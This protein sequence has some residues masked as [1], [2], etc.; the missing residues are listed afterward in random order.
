MTSDGYLLENA[1]PHAG[2]RLDALAEVFDPSTFRHIAG[3]GLSA[4]WRCWE[5][6][7]GGGSVV[8]WLAQRVGPTGHVLAT[9]I[10]ITWTRAAAADNVA[11]A[12][13]DVAQDPPPSE[14]FDLV[15][16]RLVLMHVAE[17][18]QALRAMIST[19][20]P[21]GWLLVEDGDMSLQTL[22][23]LDARSE[24]EALANKLHADFRAL[25][26]ER[27]ADP[28]YGR[29]LPRLFREAGLHDVAADGYFAIGLPAG[30]ALHRKTIAQVRD[31]LIA[32][33]RAT[34]DELDR[35]FAAIDA[36]ILEL[37]TPPIISA[38]GRRP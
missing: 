16:A 23:C 10:D 20:R 24:A 35:Y 12:C 21:G 13:H 38:W 36:G 30:A 22:A 26:A 9:D 11:I 19:L 3:L 17:R 7:A 5:V 29:K 28:A 27:G 14:T 25:L 32:G 6:G 15:H 1:A 4:G 33:G 31:R 2:L 18:D 37:A 34:A 8:R